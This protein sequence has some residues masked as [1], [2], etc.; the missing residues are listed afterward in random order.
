[1]QEK[2]ADKD[3]ANI[4]QHLVP[5]GQG[6]LVKR[7]WLSHS[8]FARFAPILGLPWWLRSKIICLQCRRH[9]FHPWFEKIPWRRKRQPI[10]VFSS[11]KF[12]LACQ[13][14][15]HGVTKELDMT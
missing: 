8:S 3:A 4:F 2:E 14:T 11:V 12:H 7:S 1:M 13:A 15:V 10:P 5:G 6:I 9:N